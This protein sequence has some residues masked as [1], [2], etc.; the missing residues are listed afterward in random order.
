MTRKPRNGGNGTNSA[1]LTPE[2]RLAFKNLVR[3]PKPDR[4]EILDM[5]V[6]YE[7]VED[8]PQGE[9]IRREVQVPVASK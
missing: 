5:V 7:L 2:Q 1:S 3:L 9:A 8:Q 6:M 4:R